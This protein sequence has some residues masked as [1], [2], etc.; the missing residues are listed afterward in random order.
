MHPDI[1]MVSVDLF[2]TFL[3]RTTLP[4]RMKFRKF[5]EEKCNLL[6][7]EPLGKK[8]TPK[9]LHLLRLYAAKIAYKNK[10]LLHGAREATLDEI[11]DVMFYGLSADLGIGLNEVESL[12]KQFREIEL[13]LESDDLVVNRQ[14][15]EIVSYASTIGKKV[16][17]ISDMYL[18][19][20]DVK[21]LLVAKGV[22][23]VF[24]QVYV[25]SEFGFGKASGYLFDTALSHYQLLSSQVVHIGDNWHADYK[26]PLSKGIFAFYYPRSFAWRVMRRLR[27]DFSFLK[28]GL[29]EWT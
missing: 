6:Q 24:D 4:E 21:K 14:L 12:K 29:L 15:K 1:C 10:R 22:G 2:D 8:V 7:S 26:V 25:S 19:S 9:Y 17:A 20:D 11:Y 23:D 13:A 3:L 28:S 5:G 27:T 16:I 18:S